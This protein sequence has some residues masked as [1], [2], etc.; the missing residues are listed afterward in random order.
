MAV[1]ALGEL[2]DPQTVPA[3]AAM[4]GDP[5]HGVRSVMTVALQQIEGE[6][7]AEALARLV[8]TDADPHTRIMAVNALGKFL[9]HARTPALEAALADPDPDVRANAACAIERMGE[10]ATVPALLA[11]VGRETDVDAADAMIHALGA[12]ADPRATDGLIAALAGGVPRLRE[13]AVQMLGKLGDERAVDPLISA[14]RDPDH[15]VRLTAVWALDAL[16]AAH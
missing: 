9:S 16:R 4:A 2:R 7:A 8:R 6:P 13:S 15:E 11:A 3:L 1:L 5:E 14:T 10:R 12:A